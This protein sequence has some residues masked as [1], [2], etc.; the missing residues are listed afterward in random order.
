MHFLSPCLKLGP[1]TR[2][3]EY[4]EELAKFQS[5][6]FESLPQSVILMFSKEVAASRLKLFNSCFQLLK[7]ALEIA[8]AY[9]FRFWLPWGMG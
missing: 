8:I 6:Y 2:K 5:N 4:P 7:R 9:V 3:G 1:L